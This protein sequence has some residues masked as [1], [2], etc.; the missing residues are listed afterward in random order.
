VLCLYKVV[1]QLQGVV[2]FL[3]MTLLQIYQGILRWKKT[4]NRLRFDRIMAMSLRPHFF[5]AHRDSWLNVRCT[6]TLTYL[7]TLY[8]YSWY[9]LLLTLPATEH[10]MRWKIYVT[11]GCPSVR[12][13]DGTD[14]RRAAAAPTGWRSIAAGWRTAAAG[15]VM[16]R[17]HR[18]WEKNKTPNSWP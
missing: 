13:I 17:L 4:V 3:T 1:W 16:L 14:G 10:S 8:A 9:A 12:P 18:E 11:D 7:L 6:N 15:R 5:G 2:R